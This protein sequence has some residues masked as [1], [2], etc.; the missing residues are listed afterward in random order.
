MTNPPPSSS[1]LHGID[2][3]ALQRVV[4]PVARA[5]GA[6]VVDMELKP[7]RGRWIFRVFVE[8]AGAS[9]NNLSTRDAAVD[10]DL[11]ANVSRDLSPALDVADLIPHTYNLEVSSPGVERPLRLERDFVRFTGQ[12]AKLKLRESVAG[13]RVLV[14]LLDGVQR[15]SVRVKE[16]ARV[17]EAPLSS[18]ESARLVFEFGVSGREHRKKH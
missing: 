2:R 8:K 1:S 17:H 3:D 9:A 14:G 15:G 13:Q 18:I 11:C 4:E 5:H 6:E 12:K 7:D 10:L 16:G